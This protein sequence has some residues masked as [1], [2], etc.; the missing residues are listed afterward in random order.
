MPIAYLSLGSNLDKEHNLPAALRLL[1][2][3]GLLHAVSAVYETAPIGNPHDPAFFN[4]AAALETALP[5]AVLKQHVLATIEQQLGR[6]RSADPN[7]PRT[8]DIDISLYDDAILDLGKRHI[9][10]PEILRFPHIAVPLADL[11]PRYRHPETGQTLAE[12]AQQVLAAAGQAPLRR[13]DITT[14][15]C[16]TGPGSL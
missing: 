14:L 15:L 7:A 11:A 5:P 1:A 9:P 4:A 6:E 16:S 8:I 2:E 13:D 3:H 12:I 10:D